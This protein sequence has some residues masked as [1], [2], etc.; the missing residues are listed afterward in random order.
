MMSALLYSSQIFSKP[1]VSLFTYLSQD[2][3][4]IIVWFFLG[5]VSAAMFLV[6]I[7]RLPQEEPTTLA[8]ALV[9]A[10]MVYLIF[11]AIG[12]A[13][14]FWM[15]LEIIG[16]GIYGLMAFLGQRHSKNWLMLGWML[17][18]IWDIGLHFIKRG[19]EFMPTWYVFSCVSFDFSVAAYI[20]GVQ[21]GFIHAAASRFEGDR[22]Q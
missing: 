13:S 2:S 4:R 1:V 18:P 11:A 3:V 9:V 5:V 8:V 15:T 17:H 12:H 16:V 21:I 6:L 20:G 10:A 14:E 7:R 19:A 22:L